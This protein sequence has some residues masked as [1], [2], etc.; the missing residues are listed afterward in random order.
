[1][2]FRPHHFQQNRHRRFAIA[3]VGTDPAGFELGLEPE[4][5][6]FVRRTPPIGDGGAKFTWSCLVRHSSVCRAG[7]LGKQDRTAS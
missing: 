2:R 5:I 3:I 1:L 4:L 6:G 7:N